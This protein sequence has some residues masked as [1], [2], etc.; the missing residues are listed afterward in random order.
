MELS[1]YTFTQILIWLGFLFLIL[2]FRVL[3]QLTKKRKGI[4]L[5]AGLFCQMFLPDPKV[6]PLNL[7][8]R[9]EKNLGRL[10]LTRGQ[11]LKTINSPTSYQ[12]IGLI[13]NSYRINPFGNRLKQTLWSYIN[14][15]YLQVVLHAVPFLKSTQS[16][17]TK[18]KCPRIQ[19]LRCPATVY[20][21][22]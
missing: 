14:N 10:S 15:V 5:T 12:A 18:L 13:R 21:I 22:V 6:Q 1:F 17:C 9:R 7:S 16:L 11:R 4:A 19:I 2:L 20:R 8:L 3:N